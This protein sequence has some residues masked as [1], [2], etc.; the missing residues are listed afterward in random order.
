MR[1]AMTNLLLRALILL[2]VLGV[3]AGCA[4][5]NNA[6]ST[7][8][9]DATTFEE[10][11]LSAPGLPVRQAALCATLAVY[12]NRAAGTGR[13]IELNIAKI[14]AVSRNPAPDPLFFLTG[15]PGQAATESYLQLSSA[16]DRI[17]QKRD[18]ILV[19]QRGTGQSNPL[20]CADISEDSD[21][22]AASDEDN[23]RLKECLAQLDA[24]PTL[25]TTSIAMQ[26]L[27]QVRARPRFT[28]KSPCTGL[29][30]GTWG[31]PSTT[32]SKY[33]THAPYR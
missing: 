24:D 16:F 6:P 33:S 12:E 27:D 3:T 30:Y 8:E 7:G 5:Q 20:D 2:V 9:Q 1:S 4:S 11:Q 26:D 10:C 23:A 25:Y 28:K 22:P 19:D 29:S 31:R 15:G 21:L 13:Q 18:I 32:W 17:N 14:P